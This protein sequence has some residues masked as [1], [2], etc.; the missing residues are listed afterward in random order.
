[1]ETCHGADV[2][3]DRARR[4]E[5]RSQEGT[6]VEIATVGENAAIDWKGLISEAAQKRVAELLRR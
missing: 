6:L 1:M 4:T 3:I 2:I 5:Y